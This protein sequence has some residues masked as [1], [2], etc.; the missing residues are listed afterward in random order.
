MDRWIDWKIDKVINYIIGSI[1]IKINWWIVK[2]IDVDRL[3]V[4]I[5]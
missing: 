1:M 5:I 4:D 3:I 2:C